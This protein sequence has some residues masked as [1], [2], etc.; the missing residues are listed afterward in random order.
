MIE[1]LNHTVLWWHWII[2]GLVL[3]AIEMSTGTLIILGFGIASVIVGG[4]AY[5][6][7]ID[8]KY[9]L[10]IWAGLST[11]TMFGWKKWSHRQITTDSGQ[12]HHGMDTLGTV[13]VAIAPN[14]RG[15]VI[16]DSPVLGNTTWTA[17]AQSSIDVDSRIKI[18]QVRGQL[19][20][21]AK[22]N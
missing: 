8:I 14:R 9:Q 6:W 1:F 16:F 19:I 5:V 15:T 2:L 21:V 7:H 20:E 22:V 4:L 17:T 11:L 13:S 12:S 18:V 10:L 3:L